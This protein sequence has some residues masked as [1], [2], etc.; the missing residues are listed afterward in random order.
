MELQIRL[1]KVDPDAQKVADWF[2]DNPGRTSYGLELS[3]VL[4]ITT[5][6]IYHILEKLKIDGVIEV[7]EAP[8]STPNPG[9][10]KDYRL[11]RDV[12]ND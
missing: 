2:E 3:T 9:R 1:K 12:A 5:G 10:R 6:K 8:V 11:K 7:V 4:G